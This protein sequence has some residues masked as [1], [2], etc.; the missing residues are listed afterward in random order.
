MLRGY[1]YRVYPTPAQEQWLQH[2]LD[3]CRFVYNHMLDRQ[4]KMYKRRG[5][6]LSNYDMQ[7]LLPA[8]KQYL[9]WLRDTDS[10]SI[11]YACAQVADAYNNF[12]RRVKADKK[13][14]FP[15][16]KSRKKSR[17]S[18]TSTNPTSMRVEVKRIKLPVV[19]WIKA[20][21]SRMPHGKIKRATVSKTPTGKWYVSFLVDE[22]VDILPKATAVVGLDLGIKDFAVDSNGVRYDNPKYL[23]KA[24]K[25]LAREQ[26]R[27][28]RKQKGSNNHNKQRIKVATVHE[29][30]AN[31][32]R[33]HHHKL[34]T[35]LIYENQ[36][37]C[38]EDLNIG[39]MIKNHC[40]AKSISSAAWS[41]FVNMLAY[42]SDWYGRT[43]VKVP[44]FYASSQICSCC[45][46]QNLAVRDLTVRKWICPV[47]GAVHD[48]D[49]NAAINILNKGLETLL[50][51]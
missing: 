2:N 39:G 18:Y 3:C 29:H 50:A 28:S 9:P 1:K 40:L 23:A 8:M 47:C 17:Q 21:V 38:I 5:E 37:I 45:G 24:E 51:A 26:R 32:C 12:F 49:Y 19:G 43:L 48:R 30:V 25:H 20:K 11:K 44:K 41:E 33:D 7:Y 15:K 22:T 35:Q 34:S 42:K 6:H 4:I 16:F 27:L 36:V 46:N 14:G 10:Q 31:Q 13:P